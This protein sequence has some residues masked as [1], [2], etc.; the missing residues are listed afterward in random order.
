MAEIHRIACGT[1]NCYIVAQGNDA[2][3]VDTGTAAFCDKVREA[4]SRYTLKLIVLTHP[5]FDHAENAAFLSEHF[6]VPVAV[7][8]AD[9]ELFENYDAQ[10]LHSYG[11][12][13]KLVL[14]LSLKA[15][16]NTKVRR[17]VLTRK[18][19]GFRGT[20]LVPSASMWSRNTC[21]QAMRSTTGS[22]RLWGTC[23]AIMMR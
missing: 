8:E 15:L 14:G 4:C 3:L 1:D 10:P 20:P 13:G 11:L 17:P 22:A 9:L 19:L 6:S 18:S 21:W 5:H 16:R 7:H 2:L 12:V 23:T